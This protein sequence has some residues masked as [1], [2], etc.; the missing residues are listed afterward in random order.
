MLSEFLI[1][2]G[3]VDLSELSSVSAS[4]VNRKADQMKPVRFQ[5][6]VQVPEGLNRPCREVLQNMNVNDEI[7][8][9]VRQPRDVID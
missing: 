1:A 9:V 5:R 7:V 3:R 2:K 8:S 6:A 4:R